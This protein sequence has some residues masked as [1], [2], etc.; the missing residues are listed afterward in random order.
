MEVENA[1]GIPMGL[2]FACDHKQDAC[3]RRTIQPLPPRVRAQLMAPSPVEGKE[4]KTLNTLLICEP[5]RLFIH[6]Q[7]RGGDVRIWWI[8]REKWELKKPAV[9][10]LGMF[11][12][13]G[14]IWF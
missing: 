10:G 7:V 4:T 5:I 6:S 8:V 1:K 14:V 13:S 9:G 3:D 2:P 11:W 12:Y